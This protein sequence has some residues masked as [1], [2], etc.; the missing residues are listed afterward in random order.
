MP[1]VCCPKC[2]APVFQVID[3][4]KV[5]ERTVFQCAIGG[6]CR[7]RELT[8]QLAEA[9]SEIAAL[10]NGMKLAIGQYTGRVWTAV[11][12]VD[13]DGFVEA[14]KRLTKG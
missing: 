7:I 5:S 14:A 4:G 13:V 10:R 2:G 6:Q 1:D 8:Q 9:Q 3:K 11:R 12:D